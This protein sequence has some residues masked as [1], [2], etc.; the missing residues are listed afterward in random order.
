MI[1]HLKVKKIFRSILFVILNLLFSV[2]VSSFFYLLV[3]LGGK[4]EQWFEGGDRY[5]IPDPHYTGV[6]VGTIVF[7]AMAPT[8]LYLQF[9]KKEPDDD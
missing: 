1:L 4:L 3:F 2:T 9:K 6:M 5:D 8:V 7:L